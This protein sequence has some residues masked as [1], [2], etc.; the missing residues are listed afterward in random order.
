V[1][2]GIRAALDAGSVAPDVVAIEARKSGTDTPAR[3]TRRWP[4]P[5][6]SPAAVVTLQARTQAAAG[7]P[8][9][10]RPAPSVAGYDRLL[11]RRRGTEGTAS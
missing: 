7:L 10:A 4:T 1:L 2:A 8:P 6:R 11:A 3:P 9:D 5:R